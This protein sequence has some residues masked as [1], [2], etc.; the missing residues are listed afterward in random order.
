MGSFVK[1]GDL[2]QTAL[3]Q[4]GMDRSDDIFRLRRAWPDIVGAAAAQK[5]APE[6][7]KKDQLV[8]HVEHSVLLT[9]L[10]RYYKQAVLD[11]VQQ[12]LGQKNIQKV[13]FKIGEIHHGV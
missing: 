6:K 5:S 13:L 7:I 4:L 3:Q 10:D 8:V 12:Y 1:I 9:E 2:V 11:R